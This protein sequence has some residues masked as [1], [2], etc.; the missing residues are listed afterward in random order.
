M[1]APSELPVRIRL[2]TAADKGALA[3]VWRETWHATYDSV[4]GADGVRAMANDPT[5]DINIKAMWP[6]GNG[7]VLLAHVAGEPAATAIASL[8]DGVLFVWGMYVRPP[9]Q[10]GRIGSRMLERITRRFPQA[11]RVEVRVLQ[12]SDHAR[13]FY[14]AHGFTLAGEENRQ[15]GDGGERPFWLMAR[16][17]GPDARIAVREAEAADLEAIVRLHEA[18]SLDGHGDAW[19]PESRPAYEAAFEAIRQSPYHLLFVATDPEGVAGTFQLALTPGLTGGGALRAKLESVQVRSDLR[20]RGIGAIMVAHAEA[21][22]RRRGARSVELSSNK[23]RA[24][25]HRFYERLGY[26][27][28]HEGFKKML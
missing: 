13:A 26:A 22:A 6:R 9:F 12:T 27:R 23:K 24:D 7:C 16:N 10:R 5:G 2:A 15:I 11:K 1:S 17:L 19:T 20:S 4:L 21:E 18:D 8:R 14:A 3:A 25:A 28:S